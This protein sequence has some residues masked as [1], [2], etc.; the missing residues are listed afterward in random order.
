[1]FFM[2]D[3]SICYQ[4]DTADFSVAT[5]ISLLHAGMVA[6]MHDP[7]FEFHSIYLGVLYPAVLASVTFFWVYGEFHSTGLSSALIRLPMQTV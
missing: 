6:H 2:I 4:Q 3:G 1:M 7:Y 5:Q